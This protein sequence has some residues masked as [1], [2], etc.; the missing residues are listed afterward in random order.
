MSSQ[1]SSWGSPTLSG[2]GNAEENAADRLPSP[3]DDEDYD[4]VAAALA[5]LK[6]RGV[7]KENSTDLSF[8]TKLLISISDVDLRKERFSVSIDTMAQIQSVAI[9]LKRATDAHIAQQQERE[10]IRAQEE[11]DEW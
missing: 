7:R 11:E 5:V 2:W 8:L 4:S 9:L 3:S 1:T 6:S 10:A